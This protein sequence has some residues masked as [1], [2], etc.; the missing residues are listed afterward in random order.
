MLVSWDDSGICALSMSTLEIPVR[1]FADKWLSLYQMS[2]GRS[3]AVFGPVAYG[4]MGYVLSQMIT[5][6]VPRY[7]PRYY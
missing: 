4:V 7:I 2:T 5:H 3:D 1:I 6:N